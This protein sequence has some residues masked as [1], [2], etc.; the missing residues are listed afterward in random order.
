MKKTLRAEAGSPPR[1]IFA[2]LREVNDR[3][4]MK[5]RL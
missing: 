4:D 5:N 3:D 1:D 2:A